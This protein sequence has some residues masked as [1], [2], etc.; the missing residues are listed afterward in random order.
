MY[1]MLKDILDGNNNITDFGR[2]SIFV[3]KDVNGTPFFKY[4]CK[5]GDQ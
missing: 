3:N 2:P 1:I 4:S 5:S